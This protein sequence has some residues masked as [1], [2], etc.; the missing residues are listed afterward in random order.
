MPTPLPRSLWKKGTIILIHK[1]Q[2][3]D[4]SKAKYAVLMEN[5]DN[6]RE[7]IVFFL[8]T[9]KMRFKAKKWTSVIPSGAM[10]GL[11]KDSLIDCNNWWELPKSQ[12]QKCQYV[13]QLSKE[14]INKT[15]EAL[16][17]ARKV[18]LETIIRLRGIQINE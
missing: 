12:L 6:G 15:E 9:S 2:F 7:T 10:A 14:I 1:F 13:G 4:Y 17:Y 5:W 18:P 3:V 16:T 8:I 11:S